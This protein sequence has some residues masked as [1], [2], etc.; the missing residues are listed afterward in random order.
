[1]NEYKWFDRSQPQTLQYGV[2]MLYV[3][4]VFLLIFGGIGVGPL[5]FIVIGIALAAAQIAGALGIANDRKWGYGLGVAGAIL[6]LA[7]TLY[8]IIF[9]V[10]TQFVLNLVFD[11]AVVC[12]L[13]HP[14]SRD[15]RRIWFK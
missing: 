15:Y 11:L 5:D 4:A 6:L 8:E 9:L 10:D 3:D 13:L 12:L 14:Q 1:M 2:I 7:Y